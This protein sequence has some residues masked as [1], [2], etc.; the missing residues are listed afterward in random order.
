MRFVKVPDSL[1]SPQ[2]FLRAGLPRPTASVA[3]IPQ[4][5]LEYRTDGTL[6]NPE[7]CDPSEAPAGRS[8][9]TVAS[10]GSPVGVL[11][12]RSSQY[13][14]RPA[15]RRWVHSEV[16]GVARNPL[17]LLDVETGAHIPLG[18]PERPDP[19]DPAA[20]RVVT[21]DPSV[22]LA[23]IDPAL[24]RPDDAL[25]ISTAVLIDAAVTVHHDPST[26]R[27]GYSFGKWDLTTPVPIDDYVLRMYTE[28]CTD[29]MEELEREAALDRTD[30]LCAA[31]AILYEAP[32][33]TRKPEAYQALGHGLKIIEYG[34]VRNRAALPSESR[35]EASP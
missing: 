21:F 14:A 6:P 28:L 2:A 20:A 5:A 30:L 1:P 34:P 13:L 32:L 15:R 17:G 35:D 29:R 18:R 24:F 10:D 3:R 22:Y 27:G 31:T 16:H 11:W 8:I 7:E 26:G 9:T 4:V 12:V 33:Y 19:P 23:S 25:F